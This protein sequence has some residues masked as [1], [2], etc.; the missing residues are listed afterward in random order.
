MAR[1]KPQIQGLIIEIID[2]A[3]RAIQSLCE[4]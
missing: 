4:R 3:D 2:E 1:V